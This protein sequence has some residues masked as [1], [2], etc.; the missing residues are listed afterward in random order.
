MLIFEISILVQKRHGRFFPNFSKCQK[1][2]TD[3]SRSDLR[4]S[5]WCGC[6]GD[7]FIAVKIGFGIQLH[8]FFFENHKNHSF[9]ESLGLFKP[10]AWNI[11]VLMPAP[12][13]SSSY[14]TESRD[15]LEPRWPPGGLRSLEAERGR[16]P[17]GSVEAFLPLLSIASL[18]L[19]KAQSS[20]VSAASYLPWR[21][22][23]A[24]R[25]FRVVVT[26]GESTLAALCQPPYSAKGVLLPPTT[27]RPPPLCSVLFLFSSLW[28]PTRITLIFYLR[29]ISVAMTSIIKPILNLSIPWNKW[30]SVWMHMAR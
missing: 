6:G 23:R 24:P 15:S 12:W 16:L 22:Y 10:K 13:C 11:L 5:G 17:V 8:K 20:S 27:P 9:Q 3:L 29:C 4:I 7:A 18:R 14:C 1:L 25:F 21:R 28:Y 2:K 30:G 19:R 26:V